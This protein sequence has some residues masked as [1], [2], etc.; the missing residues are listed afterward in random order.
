MDLIVLAT[1]PSEHA[2]QAIEA[3]NRGKH[4]VVDKPMCLSL[5][6]CDAMIAAADKADRVLTVFQN[7]RWGMCV[8]VYCH[9]V[10]RGWV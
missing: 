4:V 5:A 2:S 10:Q 7:R 9:A 3:L 1:P 8:C 6:D